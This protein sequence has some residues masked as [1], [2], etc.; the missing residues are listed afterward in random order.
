MAKLN[1]SLKESLLF[2]KKFNRYLIIQ[3]LSLCGETIILRSLV[4]VTRDPF[5]ADK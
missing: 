2:V 3:G 1:A 5:P 4:S